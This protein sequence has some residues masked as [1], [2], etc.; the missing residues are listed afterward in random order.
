M[1]SSLKGGKG[2]GMVEDGG[3]GVVASTNVNGCA[4]GGAP[5]GSAVI[6]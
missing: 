4:E 3:I 1:T 2:L 5:L 6:I